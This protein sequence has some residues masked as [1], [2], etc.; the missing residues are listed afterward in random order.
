MIISPYC[1]L[2]VL[3]GIPEKSQNQKELGV[4]T[5]STSESQSMSTQAESYGKAAP[6][7][8][9]PHASA[10]YPDLFG[11][12]QGGQCQMLSGVEPFWLIAIV[13]RGEHFTN[14]QNA[15]LPNGKFEKHT[16]A[17]G[18]KAVLSRTFQGKENLSQTR[19]EPASLGKPP[20]ELSLTVT[21]VPQLPSQVYIPGARFII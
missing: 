4:V 11:G 17:G 5:I 18:P 21:T 2:L 16:G 20:D 10:L 19:S 3:D 1:L 15:L 8:N 9:E 7:R 13:R 12:R 6:Q 14:S